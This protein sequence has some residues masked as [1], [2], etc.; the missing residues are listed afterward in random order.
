MMMHDP[1]EVVVVLNTT[2]S[3]AFQAFVTDV[4]RWWPVASF[5]VAGGSV[6][7][8]PRLGG[9]IIET[10]SD[11]AKHVWGHITAWEENRHIAL[12]WYVGG[13]DA[14]PTDISVRFAPTDDGR[15]GVTLVH[16][17]WAA[18]GARAADIRKNYIR[19]WSAILGEAFAAYA[20]DHCPPLT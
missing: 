4:G 8:E 19:G 3:A 15:T 13:K 18:L 5:S 7:M 11:G 12:S 2:Q 9:Q 10:A 20:A 16:D 1:I 6:V 14:V 17:G